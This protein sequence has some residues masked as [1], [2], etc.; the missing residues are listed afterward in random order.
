[1]V[2]A[3]MGPTSA[4]TS[5]LSA[6]RAWTIA[7]VVVILAGIA[8]RV[9]C[10]RGDLWFDEI[11]SWSLARQPMSWWQTFTW[12][13]DNNH[14]L[15]TLWMRLVGPDAGA[16]VYRALALAS[17]IALLC[18]A[19]ITA[20]DRREAFFAALLVASSY[21]LAN[22]SGEARGYA[23]AIACELGCIL[24]ARRAIED[25][26]TGRVLAFSALAILG[27]SAHL[28]FLHAYGAIFAWTAL[29]SFRARRERWIGVMLGLHAL[30]LA[31]LV[32]QYF[33]FV[34]HMQIG[35]GPHK[36]LVEVL[37]E[38]L[39]WTFGVPQ[40]AGFAVILAVVALGIVGIDVARSLRARSDE[41]V[42]TLAATCLVPGLTILAFRP[43]F[44]A[45]RYFLTSVLFFLLALARIAS[46][47][48]AL[49][50]VARAIVLAAVAGNAVELGEFLEIGRGRFS[51]V[52]GYVA[53]ET[54]APVA[55]IACSDDALL[56]NMTSYFTPRLP[57]APKLELHP[58]DALPSK[59]TEWILDFSGD[60]D[61]D[62][63]PT[64][65]VLGVDYALARTFTYYGLSG[66]SWMLYLRAR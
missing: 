28:T 66:V 55:T 56:F 51:K 37:G 59:G 52:L 17:G 7:T 38:T 25:P 29:A 23:T 14:Q 2:F 50:R 1:M 63:P 13:H 11:W 4:G 43:E 32:L 21:V 53:A 10:A 22:Y 26:R 57:R 3:A 33:T 20:R 12:P 47:T 35:G 58:H 6:N 27:A 24:V 46:R 60:P 36:P 39:C 8:V 30:P 48:D 15:N 41:W 42:L 49:G 40:S 31:F 34:R 9:A 16:L 62:A 45:P 61:P 64:M 18:L 65:R 54:R 5:A 44:V 19:P